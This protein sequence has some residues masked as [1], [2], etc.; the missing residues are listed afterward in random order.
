MTAWTFFRQHRPKQ[1]APVPL[2]SWGQHF[3]GI[4]DPHGVPPKI[5]VRTEDESDENETDEW[6]NA[7][8]TEAEVQ[9]RIDK[10]KVKKATGVD[11]IADEHI[12]WAARS[13]LPVLTALMNLAL[14]KATVPEI[15]RSAV[16]KVLYKGR[17]MM[18]DPNNY[19]GIAL[20]NTSYKLL[21][22]LLNRRIITQIEDQLV[23]EQYGFRKA[24][25]TRQAVENIITAILNARKK[26]KGKLYAVFIDFRKA[27]PSVDK[28]ILFEK[29]QKF[30]LK[31]KILRLLGK[32]LCY[33]K[34]KVDDGLR[35][36][37]EF[38]QHE[39]LFEG[40]SLS[41][42]LFLMFINDLGEE[43]KEICELLLY[44]DD[45]VIWSEDLATVQRAIDCLAQWCQRN[46][47][48]VNLAKTKVVKFR[49]GGRLARSDHLL[50]NGKEVEFVNKYEYLGVTLSSRFSF[51]HHVQNK[52]TK[53]FSAIGALKHVG[54]LS[55]ETAYSIFSTKVQPIVQY[56]IE[57]LAPHLS[58]TDLKKIDE[59][60]SRF[61]KKVLCVS[62]GA[63][64][65]LAL[66]LCGWSYLASML[67]DSGCKFDD[68]VWQKYEDH[69]RERMWA[70][71]ERQ[72]FEGPAFHNFDWK[73]A[74]NTSRHY[75]TRASV[76]GFHNDFCK[77]GTCYTA[78]ELE[79]VCRL[80]DNPCSKYHA[81]NCDFRRNLSWIDRVK[82]AQQKER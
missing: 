26:K 37:E 13:L 23:D 8:F 52:V 48:N 11:R 55:L 24:R 16:L 47:M 25:C 82:F 3:K 1:I 58:L 14:S 27:F 73:K 51:S 5:E 66:Q 41:P 65:S 30:G 38:I 59:C 31:G 45:L 69:K 29:L 43:L 17:G 7:D 21:T 61:A 9:S 80:C 19:R 40:D 72:E 63:S 32:L 62:K 64:T 53:A 70:M 22:S 67:K 79:C 56:C 57:P 35:E 12:I 10:L 78:D 15:W 20:L 6:Y 60:Q 4:V 75:F 81:L 71:V 50:L 74:N 49:K 76:H 42:T 77:K 68:T 33:N 46:R 36:T 34:V 28:S 54:K 2:D 39:G 44:A 18:S